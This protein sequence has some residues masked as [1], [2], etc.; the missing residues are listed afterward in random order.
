MVRAQVSRLARIFRITNKIIIIKKYT[1]RTQIMMRF[2]Y[3]VGNIYYLEI[4]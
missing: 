3:V 4:E 2:R 1:E